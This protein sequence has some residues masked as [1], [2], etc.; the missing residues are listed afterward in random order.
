MS[1]LLPISSPAA[2]SWGWH[3]LS[4]STWKAVALDTVREVKAK[5][6]PEGGV[7]VS[8]GLR[9][10][11]LSVSDAREMLSVAYTIRRERALWFTSLRKVTEEK[12]NVCILSNTRIRFGC[13][14]MLVFP[15]RCSMDSSINVEIEMGKWDGFG[16]ICNCCNT[17]WAYLWKCVSLNYC[18][19]T[20]VYQFKVT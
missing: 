11:Y 15:F 13:G 8:P 5:I 20:W 7:S 1:C 18:W 6:H 9:W 19:D 16:R 10:N 3:L 14:R 12:K 2:C 4:L 17:G